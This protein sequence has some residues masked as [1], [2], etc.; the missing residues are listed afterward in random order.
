[1]GILFLFDSFAAFMAEVGDKPSPNHWLMRNDSGGNFE[2]GNL[3]WILK[4]KPSKRKV[5]T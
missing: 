1:V 2:V 4:N 5:R 3:G